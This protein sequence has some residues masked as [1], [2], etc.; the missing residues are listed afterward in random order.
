MN[1]GLLTDPR[2]AILPRIKPV[3]PPRDPSGLLR[4]PLARKAFVYQRLSTHEQKKKS[5]WSLEM[6]D[7]LF[8]QA[9]ADGYP[10]G[11]IIVERGDL[12]ISG[13]KGWEE[14]PGLAVLIRA[15]EADEIEAVYVVH[16]SRISRDQTLI[17]GLEFG[18]LCKQHGVLIVMPTMRLNLR[19]AMHMRL[20]RQEIERAA[21]EIELLK[22]RLGGPK[23]HKALSGR[24]DGRSV[25]PGY[26]VDHQAQSETHERYVLYP[27]HAEVVRTIFQAI[28]TAGTPTRAARWLRDRGV[29]F[30]HFG[31]EVPPENIARSS[32][33]RTRYSSQCPGGFA[34]SPRLVRSIVTNPVY[35]GWWLVEGQVVHTANHPAIIDEET[36]M[37]AQERLSQHGRKQGRSGGLSSPVP[38]LLSGLL[39][40]TR[41]EMPQQMYGLTSGPGRY[42]CDYGYHN[43]QSDHFCTCLDARILDEP[44]TDLVL[45]RCSF[46][47]H[48]EAVLAQIEAE[49]DT[50]REEARRRKRELAHLQQEVDTLK[51]NL[52]LTRTPAQ[53]A[54][55][56]EQIDQRM[57]RMAELADERHSPV[58]K[59]LSAAQVATVKAFLADL[60]TGW[61]QQS[62]ALKNEFLRLILASV[63]VHAARDH[64]EAMVA[65]RSGTQQ[66]LWI[67]RPP[68]R[69]SGKVPWTEA[70]N[71]WLQAR[72]T[73]ATREERQARFPH[74]TQ[75]AIRKQAKRLGLTR[76]QRGTSK[77]HR[78]P[79]TAADHECLQAYVAGQI[80][81]AELCA[82]LPGR[83]WD[84]I[85][86]QQRVLGLVQQHKPDYYH[87]GSSIRDIVSEGSS[88]SA[89]S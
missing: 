63:H 35:L 46:A 9:R 43:A 38:Q 85:E 36:F 5:L 67:E 14:R 64:V 79:W 16:I 30:P 31:P 69:R 74:R 72:Y 8:D 56:F 22:M 37:L 15:I 68:R 6:Q 52:A 58:G 10:E 25:A 78:P 50:A 12:G 60:R 87:V 86:S 34:I 32:L 39:W 2:I 3:P 28:I 75:M 88:S 1:H 4:L 19:D 57:Q 47:E 59:V 17:D 42:L 21:D 77:P 13:T 66:R 27:P 51:Q 48:A 41:H 61:A 70:D 55:I 40:C 20:Y 18:E 80:S 76:S 7:A 24:F 62:P 89:T 26:L 71:A 33:N 53:V 11:Q 45:R 29:I 73:T 84:A 83:T 23:R 65:W 81:A 54:I 44:I 49:Y 82:M